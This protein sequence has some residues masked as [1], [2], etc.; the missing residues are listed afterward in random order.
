[1]LG[2]NNGYHAIRAGGVRRHEPDEPESEVH[3]DGLNLG[4]AMSFKNAAAQIP[5]GGNKMTVRCLPFAL[6]D[7]PRL[8]FL[9][10]CIDSGNFMTGPD[11]G[12]SPKLSDAMRARFTHNIM[13]GPGGSM[14]P[15]GTPTAEGCFMAIEQASRPGWNG[16]LR[17]RSVA[18]QGLGAVGMCR[19]ASL[20]PASCRKLRLAPL[21]LLLS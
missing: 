10:Y 3:I 21:F 12:F 18:I 5:F 1:M 11:M 2:L 14:G 7:E 20:G 6:D 9:A 16:G 15:T 17:G 4:R 8:G 19:H 13:G